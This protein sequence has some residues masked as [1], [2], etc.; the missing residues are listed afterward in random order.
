M[1]DHGPLRTPTH[2][3]CLPNVRLRHN[4][5]R[6]SLRSACVEDLANDV[7]R[8]LAAERHDRSAAHPARERIER[9]CHALVSD[10]PRSGA[11]LIRRARME[12]ASIEAVLLRYLA[13][14][15]RMLGTWWEEDRVSFADVMIGTCRID[16]IMLGLRHQYTDRFTHPGRSAMF[17]SLPGETHTLGIRMA[18]ELFRK[19]GWKI[20]LKVGATHEQLVRDIRRS[21]ARLVGLSL[22][23]ERSLEALS[24]LV[25]AVRRGQ[26][27]A[28]IFVS[29]DATVELRGVLEQLDLDGIADDM[30]TARNLMKVF[31]DDRIRERHPRG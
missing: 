18:T 25:T 26:P 16:S 1:R 9:L 31:W 12:G 19:E 17:A 13:E 4:Q 29:G 22:S 23:G 5:V 24:R 2:A 7:I 15:A 21:Q 3:I 8:R 28:A 30:A 20:D 10:D 11:D 6:S 27:N 14:A